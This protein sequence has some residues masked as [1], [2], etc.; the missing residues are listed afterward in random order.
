MPMKSLFGYTNPEVDWRGLNSLLV[1]ND[2]E[3]I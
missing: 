2:L 1:K 3:E